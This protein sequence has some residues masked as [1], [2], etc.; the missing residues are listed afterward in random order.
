MWH[1]SHCKNVAPVRLVLA[2]KA[3]QLSAPRLQ[4]SLQWSM[5]GKMHKN[6][7]FCRH[8]MQ[9]DALV[10]FCLRQKHVQAGGACIKNKSTSAEHV[11]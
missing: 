1:Q 4:N 10:T 3:E 9:I 5:K 11:C 8:S 7:K 6:P 2:G